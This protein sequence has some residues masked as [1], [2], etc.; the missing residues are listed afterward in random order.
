MDRLLTE[1]P[2][3]RRFG[4]QANGRRS[5]VEP[6]TITPKGRETPDRI[7]ATAARLMAEGGVAG[8][9][10]GQIEVAANVSGSQLYHYFA[11]KRASVRA[12]INYQTRSF[13]DAQQPYLRH[14]E[15]IEAFTGLV[16]SPGRATA[17]DALS[18]WLSA[19]GLG[20]RAGRGVGSSPSPAASPAA[21][22]GCGSASPNAGPGP[23]TS[24]PPSPACKPSQAAD[25][26]ELGTMKAGSAAEEHRVL[27]ADSAAGKLNVAEVYI[28][29]VKL[30]VVEVYVAAREFGTSEAD[31]ATAEGN[32]VKAD[33]AAGKLGVVKLDFAA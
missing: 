3:S 12:I 13:L 28:P 29:T 18:G 25:Q 31:I 1:E 8:T 33:S 5:S 17:R 30:R 2:P 21:A 15:G 24:P 20:R 22:A 19:W 7:V 4:R 27:N 26:P 6:L 32:S 23:R 16:R 9:T 11:D 14:F 10:V